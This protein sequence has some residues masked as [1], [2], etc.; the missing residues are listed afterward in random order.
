MR[1]HTTRLKL[2]SHRTRRGAA[3]VYA[4]AIVPVLAGVCLLVVD[5]GHVQL[6]RLEMVRTADA[7][8]RYAVK[9]VKDGTAL[10]KANW[11]GDRNLVDSQAVVFPAGDVE[12]G[13]WASGAFTP[14][15]SSPNAVRVTVRRTAATSNAIPLSFGRFFGL[16]SSNLTA[17]AVAVT[18][19]GGYGIVGLNSVSLSGGSTID[20]YSSTTGDFG[21]QGTVASNGNITMSGSA[22]ISGSA[23]PGVGK[24]VSAGTGS[25]SGSTA[26]LT[27]AL[28]Y[29]P[30]VAS[31]YSSSNDNSSIPTGKLSAQGDLSLSGSQTLTLP[32]GTYYI[33]DLTVSGNA[34]LSFSGPATVCIYGDLTLSG[35]AQTFGTTP[36][37]L[38]IV[39]VA[40]PSSGTAGKVTISGSAPLYAS[41]YAPLSQVKVSGSGDFYG[42]FV[43]LSIDI[44]GSAGI[45][46]DTALISQGTVSLVQ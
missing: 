15:G 28:S 32:G 39:M 5:W 43:G 41:V 46:G 26:P 31:T 19:P 29:P 13:T 38:K 6:A 10:T 8:A 23:N 16:T 9:G 4:I 21:N 30:E 34:V 22:N 24:T 17:Q 1:G 25:V 35:G 11:I 27:S 36:Q 37:N 20:S 3:F 18:K 45:H 7:A 2:P 44:S 42:Q 12:V 14:G 40:D 33:H